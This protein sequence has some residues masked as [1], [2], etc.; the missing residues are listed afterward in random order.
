METLAHFRRQ[1][2]ET[3]EVLTTGQ[4]EIHNLRGLD[5]CRSKK[6]TAAISSYTRAIHL[7]PHEPS[8]YFHRAEAY[9]QLTE[10]SLA[11]ANFLKVSETVLEKQVK[12]TVINGKKVDSF[13]L[14]K[15]DDILE[16][17]RFVVAKAVSQE[18]RKAEERERQEILME[19]TKD[20]MSKSSSNLIDKS[21][22]ELDQTASEAGSRN[23]N[24]DLVEAEPRNSDEE[25]IKDLVKNIEDS[26]KNE[27]VEADKDANNC[28][29]GIGPFD[30]E[31]V[32]KADTVSLKQKGSSSY[33]FIRSRL[34]QVYFLYAQILMDQQRFQ[35][36]IIQLK[37]AGTFGFEIKKVD[38]KKYA[39][40]I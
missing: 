23:L 22:I 9:L 14:K 27:N 35:D 4:A 17:L 18:I 21:I 38:L 24:V 5:H 7:N 3:G 34:S 16:K 1:V 31:L 32:I 28:N 19:S 25:P 15:N 11:I 33:S 37:L 10:F 39:R 26:M 36:A 13:K 12:R 6:Y 20:S 29:E 40:Q 8:Y 2:L 30:D